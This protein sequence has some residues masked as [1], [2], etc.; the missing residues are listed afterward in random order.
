MLQLSSD[1]KK[2]SNWATRRARQA[3][4]AKQADTAP[5]VH[6]QLRSRDSSGRLVVQFGS[7]AAAG[8]ALADA[9]IVEVIA[10]N[11]AADV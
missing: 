11:S 8:A 5:G 9:A 1:N 2:G 4:S 7:A 10:Q 6:A 3:Q